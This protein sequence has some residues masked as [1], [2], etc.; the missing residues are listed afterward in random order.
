MDQLKALRDNMIRELMNIYP[1]K[2]CINMISMLFYSVAGIEKKDF[3]PDP[4]RLVKENIKAE[5]SAKFSELLNNKP[6]QYV[7]GTAYFYDLELEVDPSV[8]IPRPETE[9]LVKWVA[10]DHKEEQ[11]LKVLD[12]GTGSGCIILALSRLLKNPQI[13][14]TDISEKALS[15]ATRNGLK[16]GIRV[17]FRKM[18]ILDENI[19]NEYEK[20]DIIVSNPPYV[21]EMEKK[22]MQANVLEYEPPGALFVPDDDPLL[23]YRAIARF[24]GLKLSPQG[25]L[26]LEINE[27]LG[28]ETVM[29][30]KNEGFIEI[31]LKKDMR[32][33]DRMIRCRPMFIPNSSSYSND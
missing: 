15:I 23:F 19:W 29:L 21:R 25:K 11:E 14:A 6:I 17:D 1:E 26:Y 9:E 3:L 4:E 7:T 30:L 16:Y 32:G 33:K 24:S 12:I 8:L 27:N 18:D 20:Y 5:L 28:D 31:I 13:T 2:E 10:D 22:E